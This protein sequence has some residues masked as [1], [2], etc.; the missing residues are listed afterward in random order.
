MKKAFNDFKKSVDERFA[1]LGNKGSN[2]S[3]LGDYSDLQD[4]LNKLRDEF[5]KF[6][7][8]CNNNIKYIL[9]SLNMKADK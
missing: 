8:E 3:Q 9:D 2:T 5:Y 1:N 7:D 6:K 4:L